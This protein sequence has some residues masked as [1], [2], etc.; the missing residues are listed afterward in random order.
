M[1]A[2]W[3]VLSIVVWLLIGIAFAR[4]FH[5]ALS[6][7]VEST[8]SMGWWFILFWPLWALSLLANGLMDSMSDIGTLGDRLA[9]VVQPPEAD[10]TSHARV[11]EAVALAEAQRSQHLSEAIVGIP[12]VLEDGQIRPAR[13]AQEGTSDDPES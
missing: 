12:F 10:P 3:I 1:T 7:V 4:F 2:L 8:A 9:A 13:K 6:R 11:L 5:L